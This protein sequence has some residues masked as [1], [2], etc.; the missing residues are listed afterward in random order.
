MGAWDTGLLDS[1]RALDAIGE[2]TDM[3]RADLEAEQLEPVSDSTAARTA[4]MLAILLQLGSS[5]FERHEDALRAAGERQI[6]QAPS[7]ASRGFL[8]EFAAGRGPQLAAGAG[9]RSRALKDALGGYL[10]HVSPLGLYDEPL[11]RAYVNAFIEDCAKRVDEALDTDPD[12]YDTTFAGFV[13]VI[14]I[15]RPASI[16]A[17]RVKQW[18]ARVDEA[19]AN[20]EDDGDREHFVEFARRFHIA[21]DIII[22]KPA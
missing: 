19:A 6:A 7:D 17:N 5:M 1:D 3:V 14:A 22:V 10:D 11:A 8:H 18:R 15:L 4:A 12:P 20:V 21:C 16:E 2:L 13:A 9:G